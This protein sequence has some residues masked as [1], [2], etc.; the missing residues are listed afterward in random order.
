MKRISFFVYGVLAHLLFLATY[1]WL[2]AFVGGFLV[3]HTIDSGS[4]SSAGLAVTIDLALIL[5][6][7][8]QH[9]V[10]AR[11]AFKSVWTRIVPQPIERS[12]YVYASC[13]MTALLVWQWRAVDWVVW[14]VKPVAG[15]WLLYGL[16]AA[17]WFMVPAVSLLINHFDLFGTRQVWLHLRGR[18]YT[19]LPFRTPSLYARMRHPLYVGWLIAFWATPTMTAGHLLFA[20]AMTAYIL[21]AIRFEE[22]NLIA[23]F[24]RRYEEYRRQVPMLLPRRRAAM[25]EPAS[26]EAAQPL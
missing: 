8:L 23:Y 7:G 20:A 24:G 15:R 2:A 25:P 1:A 6:F 21:V 26:E 18:D 19:A 22:R 11:P 14:D 16:F 5:A 10:M 17:G 9:S 13:V 12:T 3:A 4:G